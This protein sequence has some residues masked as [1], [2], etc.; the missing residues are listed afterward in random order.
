MVQG[1]YRV[2]G[3]QPDVMHCVHKRIKEHTIPN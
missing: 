1:E 2:H 3:K